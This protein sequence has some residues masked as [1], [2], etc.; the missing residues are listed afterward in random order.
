MGN[1][2]KSLHFESLNIFL[3]D[4]LAAKNKGP[5]L[6]IALWRGGGG[7]GK[8]EYFG[9]VTINFYSTSPTPSPNKAN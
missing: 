7:G 4:R 2:I 5:A 3:Q 8:A 1:V 6:L 9:C